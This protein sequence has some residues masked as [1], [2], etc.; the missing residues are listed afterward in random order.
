MLSVIEVRTLA[1]YLELNRA[2]MR[3]ALDTSGGI[4]VSGLVLAMLACD[5]PAR[6]STKIDPMKALREE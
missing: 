6:R 2:E 5:L 4:G 3:L 1:N